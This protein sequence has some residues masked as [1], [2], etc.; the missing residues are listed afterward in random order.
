MNAAVVNI[1]GRQRMLSQRAAMFA[2]RLTMP[3]LSEDDRQTVQNALRTTIELMEASHN[4]LLEGNSTWDLPGNPSLAVQAL[5]FAAPTHLDQLI[6]TYIR[7]GKA[8]CDLPKGTT[9]GLSDIEDILDLAYE[10]LLN[11]LEKIVLQYQIE[12]DAEHFNAQAQL[13]QAE[14]MSALGKLVAGVAH[15]INN[16]VNF[17]HGNLSHAKEYAD[18]LS[19]LIALY[20]NHYPDAPELIQKQ[21]EAIDLNFVLEDFVKVLSSMQIGSDRIRQI[22]RSLLSFSYQDETDPKP[23][24]LHEGIDNTLLIL[25]PQLN[26][27]ASNPKI[28][29]VKHYQ[30][31]PPVDCYTGQLNQV[32]M[33]I[34]SNAIDALIPAQGISNPTI[35]ILTKQLDRNRVCIQ[36]TDN[37]S[38]M[39]IDVQERIFDSFFTTKPVG[40]GTGLGLAISHDIIVKK[41][42]GQL[43][44]LSQPGL[45]TEFFIEIP[46]K[47]MMQSA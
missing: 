44:C 36:I 39:P 18:S 10:K 37:G 26:G 43:R 2:L 19:K 27:G 21:I 38:G 1:S 33:N 15:E 4:S 8:I 12:S 47:K 28:K 22:V 32:F 45:G 16:P 23:A 29:V 3:D 9:P 40:K 5:Y 25:K 11:A 13:V 17:I 42:D 24:N 30:P 14:K 7:K 41:H 35:T 31:L 46:I 20:R 34:L 6:R